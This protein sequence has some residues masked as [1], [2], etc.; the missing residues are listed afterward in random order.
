[1]KRF[2][3]VIIPPQQE[4][5]HLLLNFNTNLFGPFSV[6]WHGRKILEHL[7]HFSHLIWNFVQRE[8]DFQP[9]VSYLNA[10][11]A[12]HDPLA[13]PPELA[14]Y[15]QDHLPETT[16]YKDQGWKI[17][18]G[19]LKE[20]P[21]GNSYIAPRP[22]RRRKWYWISLLVIIFLVIL[23]GGIGG[24]WED[25]DHGLYADNFPILILTS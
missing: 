17:Q 25:A 20:V 10:P 4:L 12:T 11:E 6:L 24:R 3:I 19:R 5:Q 21:Q 13:Y 16:S 7:I 18:D 15:F 2:H 9:E 8:F 22:W 23:D 14:Y 1:M